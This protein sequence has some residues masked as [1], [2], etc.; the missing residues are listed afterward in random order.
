MVVS[1][2]IS[3]SIIEHFGQLIKH[4]RGPTGSFTLEKLPVVFEK[5]HIN[6]V[7]LVCPYEFNSFFFIFVF[8]K[9]V[10]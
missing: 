8:K 10:I 2:L 4:F 6:I 5:F 9:H 1:G 7:L 3:C